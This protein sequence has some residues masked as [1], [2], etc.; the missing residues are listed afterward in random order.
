MSR[1]PLLTA[2]LILLTAASHSYGQHD[3]EFPY[4]SLL[5]KEE[6]GA[7]R[8][9]EA[10]PEYDGRGVVVAIFDSG[11]DPGAPGLQQTTDGQP[12]IV[13]LI[14]GTG[15]GD[16]LLDVVRQPAERRIEGLTG[17]TL[18][19]PEAWTNSSGEYRLGL[20]RAYELFPSD[21]VARLKADRT[22]EWNLKQEHRAAE[23]R[24][25]I[26]AWDE[27]HPQPGEQESLPR[28]ELQAR[29]EVLEAAQ[30]AY[31][32]PGP[33]YDCIVFHD[34]RV[35]RAAIDTDEDGDLADEALLTN[36]RD[37]RQHASFGEEIRLN[38]SVNIHDDGHRLSIVTVSGSHGTH[39]AGIVAAN[40]PDDPDRNGQAPGAQ[41]VSVKIGDTRLDGMETGV[42]LTRG[43]AAVIQN[44]CDLVNMSYGEPT[45]TPNRGRLVELLSEL[46]D[47]HNV[48]FVASAGNSGPALSTVGAPG[49][50]TSAVL[51]VAA[52]VSP[53]MMA[54]EYALREV[55]PGLPFTWS[56]RGPALDGDWGVDLLAPG[57]AIAPVPEYTLRPH[58]RMN[59][60]SMSSPTACGGIA[61]L[62]SALKAEQVSYTPYSVRR[63]LQNTAAP[64]AAL[65]PTA[66]GPGLLQVD[67]AYEKLLRDQKSPGEPERIDVTIFELGSARGIYLREPGE[68]DRVGTFRVRLTPHFPKRASKADRQRYELTL[69]LQSTEDWIE[70]GEFLHLTSS[71]ASF[72]VRVDPTGLQ[73]G[74]HTGEV[75]ATDPEHPER[76]TI[77][78]V[79]VAV[80]VPVDLP[81]SGSIRGTL[82]MTPGS[83]DRQ[84]IIVPHGATWLDVRLSRDAP[85][86]KTSDA[87]DAERSYVLH[88]VQLEPGRVFETG[89][90]EHRIVLRPGQTIV[91]SIPVTNGR[92]LELCL[93]QYWLSLGDSQ[94]NYEATFRGLSPSGASLAL[95]NDGG[96]VGIDVTAR[97]AHEVLRPHG[98][99]TTRRELLRP[100]DAQIRPLSGAR[101]QLPGLGPT[102]ELLL[103]YRFSQSA[104]GNVTP[105]IPALDELLYDGLIE[106]YRWMIFD[107]DKRFAAA[108][109]I[110]PAAVHLDAGEYVLRASLR[111]VD[112][113]VLERSKDALMALDRPLKS[114]VSISGYRSPADIAHNRP[115][116]SPKL[117]QHGETER[118]WFKDPGAAA[119][120]SGAKPGDLLIGSIYFVDGPAGH[121]GARQHPTGF[122][123]TYSMPPATTTRPE[124]EKSNDDPPQTTRDRLQQSRL[125]WQLS[126]LAK[127]KW[128]DDEALFDELAA[129]ILAAH[130]DEPRVGQIRLHLLDDENR[131]QRLDEVVAAADVVINAIDRKALAA[132]FGTRIDTEDPEQVQLRKE[133]EKQ[134]DRLVDAL[135]RKGRAIGYRELPDVIAE[136]PIDDPEAQHQAFEDNFRELA[137]WVDPSGEEH[138]LLAVRRHRR[139]ERWGLALKLLNDHMDHPHPERLQNKK[140]RDMYGEM[141]WDDWRD[142][143][144]H[145]ML[146]RFPETYQPF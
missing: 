24:R 105:R 137:R 82:E 79:P 133:F 126:E 144:H 121:S 40:F 52:Y 57:G 25:R 91:R 34:G 96:T 14:D 37:E 61:L 60:T 125:E 28:D 85:E 48:I 11:V 35:W 63:A 75:Q 90:A 146:I 88:T 89:T 132:H 58:Q 1:H 78:R 19:I 104:A 32:D 76:G 4:R 26:A 16:V 50:S 100:T 136:H 17:R 77:A 45:S 43:I 73:P 67:R 22:R 38:Y 36:Y 110:Y 56:S 142:Y 102:H 111:H 44:G 92:T 27:E 51:G 140:R 103:T 21:L 69:K 10:H 86:S 71:G 119:Q 9:L 29:L 94:L 141:G 64:V 134:R 70:T 118:V 93:A 23:L 81:A 99:L 135:Y 39:V 46:V 72:E 112:P 42:G 123:V 128:P 98:S 106:S 107:D 145:W 18:I 122:P 83:I 55:Y 12:K 6:T 80:T 7:A 95:P 74:L 120:S 124:N 68:I 20:K 8:F 131:K 113:G 66:E 47:E 129:E 87:A 138:Y 59:G 115:P 5:P 33:I 101:D 41:I 49:G 97:L 53:E 84:F 30:N 62:L 116:L 13:D 109:D 3:R 2:L 15:S 108:G 139:R 114:S 31:D 54:A 127:L 65:D 130:P 117:L 143:E